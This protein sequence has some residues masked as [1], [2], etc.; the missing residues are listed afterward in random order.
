MEDHEFFICC[1]ETIRYIKELF[2][3]VIDN[4]RKQMEHKKH[5]IFQDYIKFWK[6][7]IRIHEFFLSM[8]SSKFL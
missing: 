8:N 4:I 3:Q 7:F 5:T 1:L 6:K 2:G